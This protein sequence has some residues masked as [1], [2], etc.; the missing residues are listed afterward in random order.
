M[1]NYGEYGSSRVAISTASLR[2]VL[3]ELGMGTTQF[4]IE[5][6]HTQG[7]V[8]LATSPTSRTCPASTLRS[9]TP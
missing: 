9:I 4:A 7:R 5:G 8:T 3:K 1:S 6:L 2:H